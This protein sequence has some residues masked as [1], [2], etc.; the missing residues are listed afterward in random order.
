MFSREIE[1]LD[2]LLE[3]SQIEEGDTGVVVWDAALV[4]AKYLELRKEDICG[5]KIIELGSGTGV[6]GLAAA[7][8]GADVIVSDL[9]DNLQLMKQNISSNQEI[10]SGDIK[11]EVLVWGDHLKIK[12]LTASEDFDF[13]LAADCV[14][15]EQALD[16]LVDTI[17]QLCTVNTQVLISYEERD[18]DVKVKLQNDF[19]NL[20][21][22]HFSLQEISLE[23]QHPDFRAEDI[24]L[25][26]Y[27][28]LK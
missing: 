2:K 16:D 3:I 14:Y 23:E 28:P 5:K 26:K 25:M 1:I 27:V 6:V 12:K 20:M 15:Y 21:L 11:A 19:R 22:K 7:T 17:R 10:I 18:S 13:V 9:E 4:L 8:L 24:R